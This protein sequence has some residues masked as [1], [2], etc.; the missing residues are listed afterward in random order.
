M[1]RERID[2]YA[3]NIYIYFYRIEVLN[4]FYIANDV[5]YRNVPCMSL[6]M[7]KHRANGLP[8]LS[9]SLFLFCYLKLSTWKLKYFNYQ[10]KKSIIQFLLR[11]SGPELKTKT[12]VVGSNYPIPT[13]RFFTEIENQNRFC[14]I[15][16]LT[17]WDWVD[18]FPRRLRMS[19]CYT[20][21]LQYFFT[22]TYFRNFV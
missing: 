9:M 6:Q 1:F 16:Y 11:R 14:W 2:R 13:R 8:Q 17:I 5:D 21:C 18:S 10:K 20:C 22:K 4:E 7:G 12:S 15:K 19:L 3:M